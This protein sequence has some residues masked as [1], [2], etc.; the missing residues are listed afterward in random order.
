MD[1]KPWWQSKTIWGVLVAFIAQLLKGRGVDISAEAPQLIDGI[2]NAV[3][4][5]G[6][7]LAIYGRVRASKLIAPKPD[8]ATV[9]GGPRLPLL[10]AFLLPAFVFASSI[11]RWALDVGRWTFF[12]ILVF[13][14]LTAGCATGPVYPSSPVAVVGSDF[15]KAAAEALQ[16]YADYKSGNVD[17][18]WALTK[19]FS[20]YSEY[21][22]DS[23]DVKALIAAWTG[24][25][26]D[27]QELADRLARI[28]G[29]STAP[30]ETKMAAL[31]Q[32]AQNVA[33]A[34]TTP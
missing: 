34:P 30:P 10:I 29:A 19:M 28:F 11:G 32:I 21:A 3:S 12:L 2:L 16:A 14:L 13:C 27:S 7:I 24:N 5:V 17:L 31:A 22:Q 26:G 8:E 4:L 23:S 15:Q 18:T 6:T 25:A 9:G 33:A 1:T 20:A